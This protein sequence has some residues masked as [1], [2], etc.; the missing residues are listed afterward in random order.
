MDKVKPMSR[1]K[2]AHRN[3]EHMEAGNYYRVTK[4]KVP[5]GPESNVYTKLG[6]NIVV[7]LE[8][9]RLAAW[10]HSRRSN[11]TFRSYNKEEIYRTAS[12]GSATMD[13]LSTG[14]EAHV[15]HGGV[16]MMFYMTD[17]P[18]HEG[19]HP[20]HNIPC[21]SHVKLSLVKE[22]SFYQP[23]ATVIQLVDTETSFMVKESAV[24]RYIK[25]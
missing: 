18:E 13:V 4:R 8:Q 7:T 12:G 17:K 19:T 5:R 14:I 16:N 9:K 22:N 23:I 11:R 24:E 6:P 20:L 15:K 1:L 2:Y 21:G 25:L 10:L 3:S